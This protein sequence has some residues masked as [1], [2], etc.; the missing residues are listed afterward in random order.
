MLMALTR[1]PR[2]SEIALGREDGSFAA[3][4]SGEET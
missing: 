1:G 4:Q 2:R 3:G